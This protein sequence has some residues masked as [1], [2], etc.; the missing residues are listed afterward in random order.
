MRVVMEVVLLGNAL[1]SSVQP[2]YVTRCSRCVVI[3]AQAANVGKINKITQLIT[4]FRYVEVLPVGNVGKVGKSIR[5]R[6][7]GCYFIGC[8]GA[9]ES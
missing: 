2:W 1:S 8:I 9:V 3:E 4:S 7:M 6:R 5:L